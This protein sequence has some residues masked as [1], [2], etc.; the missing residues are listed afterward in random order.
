MNKNAKHT[1]GPWHLD[2]ASDGSM[3]IIPE[4]GFTICPLKPRGGF[5]SDIP[6]FKLMAQAPNMLEALKLAAELID[7]ARKY[8][9]K[10]MHN[11]DKFQLEN[12]CATIGK[13][14]RKAERGQE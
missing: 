6:N 12:A 4:V 13:A 10:S 1:S 5:E 14:I 3:A 7:V 2:T 9:P 11:S 8:F